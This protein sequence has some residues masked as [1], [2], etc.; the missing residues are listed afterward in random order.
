[1]SMSQLQTTL[2]T[3]LVIPGFIELALYRLRQGVPGPLE[4]T[5]PPELWAAMGISLASLV[6]TPLL[7]SPKT[8][9]TPSDV[10]LKNTS[11]ALG[12]MTPQQINQQAMGTLYSNS[13]PRDAR[14]SDLFQGDEVGNKGAV[15]LAKIQMFAFSVCLI[16]AYA[17]CIWGLLASLPG[18]TADVLAQK[19]S[20]LPQ[21]TKDSVYLLLISHAGYL[22][23]K[24]V[25]HTDQDRSQ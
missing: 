14:V 5:I 11:N 16:L 2:W 25:S 19:S 9:Q 15:D 10:A 8:D 17:S 23:S 21:L 22:G 18:T 12:D 20:A 1:M 4:I 3:I 6:G 13:S 24:A 7:L